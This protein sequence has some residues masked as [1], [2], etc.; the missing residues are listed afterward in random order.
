MRCVGALVD[1]VRDAVAVRVR[2]AALG[3]DRGARG[4]IG[5][6]VNPVEDA[7]AV[8]VRGTTLGVDGGARGCIGA[9]VDAVGHAVAVR[10]RGAA[11]GVYVRSCRRVRALVDPVVDTVVVGIRGAALG[12]HAGTHRGVR[13]LIEAV[14]Y[15]VLVRVERAALG[16]HL[17]AG[18]RVGAGV[19]VVRD[20]VVVEIRDH[21]PAREEGQSERADDVAGPI[22]AREPGA[23]RIDGA[24]L[25]AQRAPVAKEHTV[26]DAGVG[27]V[28]GEPVRRRLLEVEPRDPTEDI[29]QLLVPAREIE[30]EAR[31]AERHSGGRG[32][33]PGAR[34]LVAGVEL[35]AQESGE[36]VADP[37]AA[38]DL[39]LEG[40]RPIVPRERCEPAEFELVHALRVEVGGPADESHSQ[41]DECPHGCS[42]ARARGPTVISVP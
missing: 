41:D 30:D 10:I 11:P 38:P 14:G 32:A 24:R 39:V 40:E 35:R 31:A 2:G 5:A 15:A 1:A 18:G 20:S 12:V 29:E 37:A 33:R 21:A 9:L 26:A 42:L 28:V 13:A 17:R 25:H 36:E 7:V 22:R 27:G 4:R 19:P 34:A 16:I 23:G 8:R 6:L 3:V